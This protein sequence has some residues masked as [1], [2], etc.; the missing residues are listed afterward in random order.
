ML[1]VIGRIVEITND[2][3]NYVMLRDECGKIDVNVNGRPPANCRVGTI[4]Q[5]YG[6]IR[7]TYP[8]P[9]LAASLDKFLCE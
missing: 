7:R 5:A 1:T 3:A 4:A 8:P 6:R 9:E 2:P